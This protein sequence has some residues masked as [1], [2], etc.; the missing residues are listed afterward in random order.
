MPEWTGVAGPANGACGIGLCTSRE[1]F[2]LDRRFRRRPKTDG[3]ASPDPLAAGI[4][5]HLPAAQSYSWG[6]L[7][8]LSGEL[9]LDDL[10]ERVGR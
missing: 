6:D 1:L 9:Q 10:V 2:P 7:S 8:P 5:Q 3:E 4:S